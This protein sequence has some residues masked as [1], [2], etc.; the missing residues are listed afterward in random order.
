MTRCFETYIVLVVVGTIAAF[1]VSPARVFAQSATVREET[2]FRNWIVDRTLVNFDTFTG[3]VF[4]QFPG[5]FFAGLHG[6]QPETEAPFFTIPVSGSNVLDAETMNGLGDGG[7]AVAFAA[8]VTG[9]GLWFNSLY[10]GRIVIR[11]LDAD[12]R[13]V[14][15]FESTEQF[16]DQWNFVGIVALAP[17][18][19]RLEVE[20][21]EYATV[22]FDDLQYGNF[23]PPGG[24]IEAQ[25]TG[26][27]LVVQGSTQTPDFSSTFTAGNS[28]VLAYASSGGGGTS[29]GLVGASVAH[30][31][32]IQ[33]GATR[34]TVR[35]TGSA[36]ASQPPNYGGFSTISV[37]AGGVS[38]SEPIQLTITEPLFF[39][40]ENTVGRISFFRS[41]TGGFEGNLMLPGNYEIGF[42]IGASVAG[43]ETFRRNDFNWLLTLSR[44]PIPPPPDPTPFRERWNGVSFGSYDAGAAIAADDGEWLVSDSGNAEPA[45]SGAEI[46]AHNGTR[47]LRVTST[48]G[49]ATRLDRFDLDIRLNESSLL[50]FSEWGSLVDPTAA[51]GC[52]QLPCGDVVWL[53]LTDNRDNRLVYIL[54]RAPN[55]T[56][57]PGAGYREVFLNPDA[58]AHWRNL[59]DD[60]A[61]IPDFVPESATITSL[62]LGVSGEGQA[63]FDNISIST[64]TPLGTAE[65]AFPQASGDASGNS[66]LS[67][68]SSTGRPVVLRRAPSGVWTAT[69]LPDAIHGVPE[70]V[71]RRGTLTWISPDNGH[72]YVSVA[73]DDGLLVVDMS[74]DPM[75]VRNLTTDA[76]ASGPTP[77]AITG[78][79]TTFTSIDGFVN[80]VGLDS[81]GD[82]VRYFQTGATDGGQAAWGFMNI[83]ATQLEPNEIDTP[84]FVSNLVAYVAPWGALHVAGLDALGDIHA[85]WWAPG[86]THWWAHNLSI[87]L[88]AEPLVVE[89]GLTAYVTP[90][91]GLNIAGLNHQGQIVVRWWVPGEDWQNTNLTAHPNTE[92]S[93]GLPPELDL[94]GLTSFVTPWGTLHICG[95][96]NQGDLVNYWWAPSFGAAWR[97][98]SIRDAS[99]E[100]NPPRIVGALTGLAGPDGVISIFGAADNGDMVRY[101]WQS[102][103]G[104]T[105]HVENVSETAERR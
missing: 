5:V 89:V 64:D 58:K 90:W 29:G 2:A 103:D 38:D 86:E 26:G 65:G 63:I 97:V 96:T 48:P 22:I 8:P 11:A 4:D 20:T 93:L 100:P 43:N 42:S 80:I 59:Y 82:V 67:F 21:R 17:T 56:V 1:A 76:I 49:H 68:I 83:S 70:S 27:E 6:A 31:G 19:T 37:L 105:W 7:F 51:P 15:S 92:A 57:Q 60:F 35:L 33:R 45:S 81:A 102:T 39:A 10:D 36:T 13:Q 54:Q 41:V 18:I 25:F 23:G 50:S 3:P 55:A 87:E 47:A 14:G 30:S 66:S 71:N 104:P 16:N 24:L 91:G 74:T 52:P 85:V 34:T 94:I 44:T 53:Q 77:T 78:P 84:T 62:S 61:A 73:S 32:W 46:I 75:V 101:H 88:D 69:A 79:S 28:S 98:T 12:G 95:V 9:V 72:S 99:E 40:I